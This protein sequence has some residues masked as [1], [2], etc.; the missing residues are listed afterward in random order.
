MQVDTSSNRWSRELLG[1]YHL[2]GSTQLA[3]KP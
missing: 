1:A 2:I 3:K